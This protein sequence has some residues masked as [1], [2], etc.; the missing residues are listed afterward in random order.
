VKYSIH[1]RCDCA[2]KT[3]GKPLYQRC[4]K[5]WRSDGS[6]NSRHGKA[7]WAARVPTSTGTRL[8]RRYTYTSK[9]EAE[10]AAKHVGKLLDLAADDLTRAKIGDL[11]VAVKRNAELPAVADVQR[12]LGLGQ[13]PGAPGVTVGGWMDGWL[14]GKQRTRRLSTT[15]G[16]ESHIRLYIRPLI[17]DIP[18]ERVNPGHVERVLAAVPGSAANRHRVLATL[19]AALS[20]AVRARQIAWNPASGVELEPECPAEAATWTPEQARQFIAATAADP[21]GLAFR[22]ALL[23]GV[24][25][26][27]LLGLTWDCADLETGVLSIERTLLE[28]GGKL[29]EGKPKTRAG[30]RRVYLGPQTAALLRRHRETQE[31]EQQF[32]GEGWA[33]HGLIFCRADGT[34]WRPDYVSKRFRA[35]AEAAG[36][37]PIKLHSARHSA[38]SAMRAAGVDRDVRKRAAGHSDDE[39]HDRYTH[40]WSDALRDAASQAEGFTMGSG[41]E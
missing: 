22:V 18:L 36:L 5:L 19:R 1:V 38:I 2:D 12:R 4:P 8:V 6:W 31:L 9:A 37:P 3:T 40:F 24:R 11:V 41:T 33:D 20:A 27:E 13:D 10:A 26:G 39:V 21:L 35:L 30:E 23:T 17:G 7:G 28:L 34:P 16:Y 25:R 32:A 15:R 14:A 29:T